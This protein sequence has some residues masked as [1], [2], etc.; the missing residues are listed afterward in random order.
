MDYYSV[1]GLSKEATQEE[2]KKAYF[3]FSKIHHP[4]ELDDDKL[5]E[6]LNGNR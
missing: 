2:I 1:L 3:Y 4:D 5:D 6:A